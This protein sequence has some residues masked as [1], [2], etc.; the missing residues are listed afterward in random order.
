MPLKKGGCQIQITYILLEKHQKVQSK[1]TLKAIRTIY[2]TTK[3]KHTQTRRV[4]GGASAHSRPRTGTEGETKMA[5]AYRPP[6][7]NGRRDQ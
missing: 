5:A 4:E 6:P 1:E 3:L 7:R 2:K